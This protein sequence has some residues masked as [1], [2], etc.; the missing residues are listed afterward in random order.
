VTGRSYRR[1]RRGHRTAHGPPGPPSVGTWPPRRGG[2]GW[3]SKQA[4]VPC[5]LKIT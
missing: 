5:Y 2:P 3:P 4:V 1:R